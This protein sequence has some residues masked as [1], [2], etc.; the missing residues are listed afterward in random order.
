MEYRKEIE[1]GD[2]KIIIETGKMAKQ[3]HGSVI[4]RCGDSMVLATC[5]A[6]EEMEEDRGFFP[7]TVDYRESYSA[8]GKFP[9]GFFKREGRATTRETLTSRMI[10][11][12]LRPMFTEGFQGDTQIMIN[13]LSY[14]E[15]NDP[16]VL[17]MLGGCAAAYL[18]PVP[19]P[20]PIG[21]VRVGLLE[22]ELVINPTIEEQKKSHLDLIV[23]GTEE[24][25]V[26][27]EAGADFISENVMVEAL[28]FAHEHIRNMTK[29]LTE[30]AEEMGIE[31]WEVKPKEIDE[32]FFAQLEEECKEGIIKALTVKG[33]HASDKALKAFKKTVL[34][35][36]EEDEEQ[37]EKASAY[38]GTIKEKIFRS[39][40]LTTRKRTDGR[41]LTEIRPIST[42][43]SLLPRVHGSA[44][45][46]RGE[47]QAMVSLTY[48]TSSD[49]Q[50]IDSIR[51]EIQ[52]RFM[53]HYNFP[54]FSVGEVRPNR[55]PGRREIGHGALAERALTPVI[56]PVSSFPYTIRLV[57]DILESN[58]SSSMASVC[59]G[60]LA[61]LD[62][63]VPIEKPVAGIAMGLIK[64]GDEY[65]ILSDIQGAEDHYGDMDFKVTGTDEGITALQM[66][67]KIKG[68]T[69]ELM[70]EALEQA[71]EGRLFILN[72]MAETM[73]EPRETFSPHAPKVVNIKVPIDK[74]RDVIG[75]GGKVIRSIIE[76]TGAKIDIEDSGNCTI[77]A[78][79]SESSEQARKMVEDLIAV[80]EAGKS[81]LGKVKRIKDFGAF[82][83]ILP[84][85]EGL[86]HI[87]EIA[88]YRLR[89]V[90]DEIQEGEEIMVKVLAVE[91]NGRIK[92]S[93]KAL[94]D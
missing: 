58:G 94:L 22:D 68:L 71:R 21:A 87:S 27:V 51:G 18:S 81:Y 89:N 11:R 49:S 7:L 63:G 14:D 76:K 72:K 40:S 86:L 85:T 41:A 24:G 8:A 64:E 62:A 4:V 65:V 46:T 37:L 53:L 15:E 38:F 20:Q 29:C 10:D 60:T 57:S 54:S 69:K 16:D 91:G 83:E 12:P 45:F 6:V 2:K 32:A 66:D 3:A 78:S 47:T 44:L 52:K 25:I 31:K 70:A 48:G 67:I 17:G 73:Q 34:E 56:P 74:I 28:D 90:T 33:K 36:Y 42:E 55:G 82:V 13:V 88:N 93:R 80:P 59:G 84:G 50:T 1:I 75:P 23:A 5:C 39:Y 19:F 61:L 30:M 9:G 77:F 26:M 35:K 79:T 92:L 43:V